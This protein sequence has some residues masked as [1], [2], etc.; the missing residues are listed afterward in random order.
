MNDTIKIEPGLDLVFERTSSIAVENMWRAWTDPQTL[1]KWFCPL[2][3]KVTDCRIE[4]HPGGEFYT[5][6]Q[7]PKGELMHN[8]GCFLEV[9]EN[10][11]LVWTGMMTK[12]FRPANLSPMGFQFVANIFFTKNNKGTF[13]KAVVAHS[14]EESRKKHEQ[15]GFQEGWGKAFEQLVEIMK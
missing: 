7:G 3:W 2:P 1:M 10:K 14:D 11:K 6:M 8:H 15:M 9:I 4:L 12:D 13:Y 5:L